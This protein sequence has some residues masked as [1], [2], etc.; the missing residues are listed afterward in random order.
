[1]TA[2][3]SI[4]LG[5]IQGLT[6]F[7]PIS[8]TAH[9]RIVP[10]ILGWEDPGAQYS[11]VIQLGTLV[12]V[13]CYFFADLWR[14]LSAWFKSIGRLDPFYCFD[15]KI[16]WFLLFGS[17]L[18]GISWLVLRAVLLEPI[19]QIYQHLYRIGGGDHSP[20]SLTTGVREIQEIVDAINIMLWRM[21]QD[22][23]R[24]A[25]IHAREKVA[26]IREHIT[27]CEGIDH[28]KLITILAQVSELERKLHQVGQTEAIKRKKHGSKYWGI[29]G[30]G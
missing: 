12:A 26:A 7:L 5:L 23:D 13:I 9:L 3:Q 15:S 10:E 2:F 28:E 8:S 16:A 22:V 4:L 6:E 25:V 24:K 27:G 29:P 20:L 14:Y 1:M 30:V 21:D 11:A 19:G 18:W 17:V